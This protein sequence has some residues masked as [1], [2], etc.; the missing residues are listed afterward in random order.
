MD[1]LTGILR[2]DRP[3]QYSNVCPTLYGFIPRTLCAER[4]G[5][6]CAERT[7]RSGIIGDG[8]PM[9][10][11]VLAEKPFSHGDILVRSIPIGGLRMID[12]DE[13]DDK[14]VAVL[15]GD[16]VYGSYSIGDCPSPLIDRLALLPHVQ[17]GP[18]SGA[19]IPWR[20]PTC[21][22]GTKR[23][24]SSGAATRTTSP[25]SRTCSRSPPRRP[26]RHP[27]AFRAMRSVRGRRRAAAGRRGAGG[28]GA[29]RSARRTR[30]WWRSPAPRSRSSPACRRSCSIPSSRSRCSSRPSW[31]TPPSTPR[32]ATCARTGARSRASPSAP[33]RSRSPSSRSW[34]GC[35][36]PTCRGRPRS[37]SGA[38][39]AP[40]D[41][42]AATTVLKQ[43]RPPHR[44][45]VILEGESLFND[46]SALLVYR[47]AVGAT[48]TGFLSGW[49]V[50][51]TL[52][53]VT[54]G[55]VVLGLVL[56]RLTLAVNARINDVATA[57]VVPVLQDVRRLDPRRAAAP[58]GHHHDGGVRDGGV[59][60]RAGG[61]ARAHPHP[62]LGGVGGGGVRA[63]RARVHPGRLPAQVHRRARD[64]R[65]GGAIRGGGGGGVRRGHRSRASRG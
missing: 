41:A 47:L 11:C 49:S 26:G 8:D 51:P 60:P 15:E 12:G 44:L 55:S 35:S 53:V 42:A 40:P 9:D 16:V 43:L 24:R 63:E 20:S 7:G 29:A 58:L 46:A 2:M 21:T 64:R 13:A 17:A 61:A 57:V 28:R 65:D 5:A 14:I 25:T 23:T 59:A 33:S 6:F 27:V 54:V 1:K 10:V 31:S 38:I 48:V 45:L 3:Q 22:T 62:L 37:R 52:L 19:S 32:R 4:V 50:L 34:R 36:C 56:A 18:G 30:R 39:V